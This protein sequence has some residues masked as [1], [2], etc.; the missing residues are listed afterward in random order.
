MFPS[1]A[2]GLPY[3][4]WTE[5]ATLSL[6]SI[7]IM[8]FATVQTPIFVHS[9]RAYTIAVNFIKVLVLGKSST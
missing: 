5:C 2:M 3:K 8:A 9:A 1:Y 4:L 7:F 6:T